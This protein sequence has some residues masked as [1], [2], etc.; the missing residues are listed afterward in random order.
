MGTFDL[1]PIWAI[2]AI[3]VVVVMLAIELGQRLGKVVRRRSPTEKDSPI[4]ALVGSILGLS[5]FMMAFTFGVVWNRYDAKKT[6][7]R[8]DTSA[9]RTAWQRSDFLPDADRVE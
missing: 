8:E 3:T 7:V 9:I 2:I 5:A 1:I 6:L 4:S